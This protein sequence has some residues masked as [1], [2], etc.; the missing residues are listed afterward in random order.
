[1][2]KNLYDLTNPQ[3]LIW[4]TEEFYNGTPIENITGTV[5]IS[6]KVN[7]HLLEQAINIFVE[8][9]D[10][11]R[12]KF[13]YEN[14]KFQQYVETYSPFSIDIIDV[15]SD[16]ELHKVENEISTTVFN[17]LDS[18]LFIYKMIRF[19]DGH[20]GFIINMHHLISDAWSAGLGGSEIIKIYTRLLKNESIEDINY[21]SY[22]EY[23]NSETMYMKSE[24]FNKDKQFW[25]EMFKIIPETAAIPG[26]E[27][28]DAS[29]KAKR[30]QFTM[31]KDIINTINEYCKNSKISIFNFFMAVISIYLG[32]V[33]NL[34][35][36][37][38]GSPILNRSNVKEKRTSGMFIN[39]VPIKISLKNNM[40]FTE[41]ASAISSDLFN[42]FKHQK[43]SY[44]S[45]LED[46]RNKDNKIP[47]LY[48]ILMSYQNIRSTAQ[49]SETPF[50]INWIPNKYISEDIDIHIYDMNDTGSINI[51]YDY[52]TSKYNE[53][54]IIEIHNRILNIINQVLENKDILINKLEIVTPE[55]KEILLSKFDYLSAN[56]P[57]N[58]TVHELFEKQVEKTPN[59]IALVFEDQK[60]TYK[61]LNK[62]A[63]SLA[64]YLRNKGIGRNDVVALRIDKS[65]EM[66]IGILA[67]MKAGGCYL[68]IN[69]SYPQDRVNFMLK[70]SNAKFLLCDEKTSS[71][72]DTNIKKI[73]IDL[74]NTKIYSQNS[75]NLKNINNP[76]DLIYI[77]YTSG[78]TGTPKGAMLMHKNVVRLMKNDKFLFDFTD[79]DVWTMFHSVSFDFSVWEMYGALLYG[80]KLVVV[81]DYVA[82]DPNLYLDLMD[83][84]NV[85]VL[86]QTPTYFYN[87]LNCEI[88]APHPNLKIRYIIY[89]GEA[90]KP[91]LINA[92]RKLHPQ[93]KL[94]NMY[95][96]TETTVHVTF[97]EL[98]DT[99]LQSSVSNIGVP[100]PTLKILLLDKNLKLVPP[101][102]PG[103][104]CVCGD[105]V[106]KGYLNRPDLNKIKLCP[107]P[108]NPNEIMYRSADSAFINSNDALEYIGRIDTQVKIRGFRVELG[109]IEE[110]ILNYPGIKSCIVTTQKNHTMHD[111][112][113][114]YFISDEDVDIEN[115]RKSLQKVLPS[116]MI[117]QY[118]IKLSK[119]PYNSNGK[120]D[121]KALPLPETTIAKEYIAPRNDLDLKL[122]NIIKELFGFKEISLADSFFELGGDSLT[123]INLCAIISQ[124]LNVQLYVKDVLEHPDISDLADIISSRQKASTDVVIKPAQ[125]MDSYPLSSAQKRI[126]LS[127]TMSGEKSVL[128]N[129]PGG[130][131]LDKM[132]DLE[133]LEKC[134]NTLIERHEAFRTYFEV[135]EN[136]IMQKIKN[137]IDFKLDISAKIIS[138][139]ELNQAFKEFV[140]PFD[141][142]TAPLFRTQ[143]VKLDN[144]K[145]A[146]FLDMHHIISDGT[147]LSILV[148]ELC[149]LYN[150]ES[151]PELKITYK[152]YAVWEN[153]KLKSDA[154]KTAENFWVNQ[155]KDELPVLNLPTNYPRPEMQLFKGNKI[156]TNINYDTTIKINELSQ[157]LGI[158]PYML[159]LSAYYILL[160]KYSS[161]DDIII[162]SPIV[163]RNH[164][165]T[166]NTIGMFVNT[167]PLRTTV[168]SNLTIRDFIEN[169]KNICLDSYQHQTYPF[170]ELI[171]KL[172]IPRD[173]SRNPLFSTMF[174]YQNN[175]LN[176][177][178]LDN[179][180]TDYY[181]PDVNISKFDLS[182]EII[183]KDGVLDLSFEFA[184]SLFKES[185]IENMSK[186]YSNILNTILENVD[187]KIADIDM[188]STDEKDNIL[189]KFNN[190]SVDFNINKT[191]T[192]LFENQVSAA[193]DHIAVVFEHKELT[194]KELNKKANSLANYLVKNGITNTSTVGIMLNRSLE[195]IISIIAVL[196]AG[197]TYILIDNTL[198]SGRVKYMLNDSNATLLI[199]DDDYSINYENELNIT[200][201]DYSKNTNN[202]KCSNKLSDSFAIIYTSGSTGNP[203]GVLLQQ[204]GL[205][206]LVYSFDKL[207]KLGSYPSHLGLSSVSFDM[208]A[209]E[210]YSSIL[211]GR[212]LYLLNDEEMK[213]PILMSNIIT[214]NKVEFLITTPTKMELLLST[215][216]TA[217]C[218]KTLKGFQLGGEVFTP[219]L[220]TKLLKYT[221]AKIYNGYGPTE[222]T[223]CCSNKAVTS[224]NDINIGTPIPNTEIYILDKDMNICPVDVPG[225]L[226]VS[227]AGVSLG[228][229]NDATKTKEAFVTTNF[230]NNLVYKTNDIAKLNE[231]GEIEYIGR[232]DFQVKLNGLRIELSEIEKKLLSI[233][234]IENAVVLCDKSKTFLKAFFTATEDL[235]IPAIRKKLSQSLPLY[236]VPKYIFQ[237]EHIPM[238]MNGKIDRK[239]LDEL[240]PNVC[241]ENISYTEPET[242]LQKLFCN[243]WENIL[244]VQVGIDNDLFELGADSLSAIKFK[245]EALN[246]N[247]DIPYSDIFKYKTIRK[248]SESK[249]EENITT[250][251]EKFDYTEVNKI[252][253]QNKKQRKLKITKKTNNNVVLLG[254][255][256]F[257]GMH[258]IDSFIKNDSGIIYCV[259]RDKNGKG[260]LNRFL[261]V[262]HFY[263]G[264]SLDKYMGNRIIVL[265]GDILKEHFGLSN[266]SYELIINNADTII[267]AAAN[268]K[269]F[270]NF[271]KFKNI[272]IDATSQTIDFCKK[273]SKRLLHLSTLSISGNM[274]LDG[275]ISRDRL[276]QKTKKYFAENNLFINQSLDNVYTRSKYEAEK[277]VLDNIVDGLDAQILRLGN[278]TSRS[279]DG[280]FQINPDNNAF[281]NRLKSFVLLGIVPKSLLQQEIEFTSV[282]DCSNAIIKVLQNKNKNISVLHLYNH[283][284]T[285]GDKL[286]KV[287]KSLG[288]TINA[289]D[290]N[291]FANYINGILSKQ[292]KNDSIS[293]IIN[294]LDLDKKISYSSNTYI[295]SDFSINYL[296]RSKFKWRKIDREYLIK[297]I[298]YLKNINFFNDN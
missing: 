215:P 83:K 111:L 177:I 78:S 262:L 235:S 135:V 265:K 206:N 98:S 236:M 124:K 80:G 131:I 210:L 279:S 147:S 88:K 64:H 219:E 60:L 3:K 278:I 54:N 75:K 18:I 6:E 94:I 293:G 118:F 263:F 230:T 44:L 126:Y 248:L 24:R 207:M 175:G 188:L 277:I 63:N 197:G 130:I 255:N 284:H 70:D 160:K 194:Y 227:G 275:T 47:N 40:K 35:E 21:P 122:V 152:D 101:G 164:S 31:S 208:F 183:P 221:D 113:Y 45:L 138:P 270:G 42:I 46:L 128:Y 144:K 238:T 33:S 179:I 252:L 156:H 184:T 72:I 203:K 134:F 29:G 239:T 153:E 169:V 11:F 100:I 143:L 106:F 283:N 196:K 43:Y 225:E 256:G 261:D 17:V 193:P 296:L 77:I 176:E 229:V 182:L 57:K 170:D 204:K 133:K 165:E 95:G 97:K 91:T 202:L 291:E 242:E 245:V 90:L 110:K 4:F 158:T 217:K 22:I 107:N 52:R 258:I 195:M 251:I 59:N 253:K 92:W 84:E 159:L 297:Y 161:Q 237:I 23:I 119:W 14:Q 163:G 228:Y 58:K 290:D 218:L 116:Y 51:A 272:N 132:P 259:M 142:S 149:K 289:V 68:P 282:D 117:P 266:K 10:S 264:N 53:Q 198:P 224:K 9:N 226:C 8:K 30:K 37:V 85:T 34:D 56:Y 269:H 171:S 201:F 268:V 96:I 39:T 213:N 292:S 140:R 150:G 168:A 241:E 105:G 260:A 157:K 73:F 81:P 200:D 65:L 240:K 180:K 69:L 129:V 137:T 67:I 233:K 12:L 247:I 285:T 280:K 38:I 5:L 243:I 19:P 154:F 186:H 136:D 123:A 250:P 151:L 244:Q 189:H 71:D 232:N 220:Y 214:N 141:L 99:D 127:S 50:N 162:G 102:V 216:S 174:V 25:N 231:D 172:N 2:Q 267:N 125:K 187:L 223:A 15:S 234:P 286:F 246:N 192:E 185:F 115:L 145:A 26:L 55:E 82:K 294:D 249:T 109:E 148:D 121:K 273:Y 211:L 36:F 139:K 7:F 32:R 13:F 120:I 212:T 166:H 79:K 173:A 112:L 1:M 87:L 276:K 205:I 104:I 27:S 28:K 49:T 89:G 108:Y 209:V 62:K 48:N 295:K 66:I 167:L 181:I 298:C 222:I 86:N 76:L 114:A 41:L 20:G 191:I 190:T 16:E 103:E 257:V 271:D 254:C 287:F 61:E 281:T 93:T 274:F 155:F 146:L 74:K 199:V 288:I 178:K